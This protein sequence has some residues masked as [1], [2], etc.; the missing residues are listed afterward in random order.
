M[1]PSVPRLQMGVLYPTLMRD[2]NLALLERQLARKDLISLKKPASVPLLC[3]ANP[4]R[5]SLIFITLVRGE[6]LAGTVGVTGLS[7][8]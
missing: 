6:N 1:F 5:T 3:T 7:L 2:E 8:P 4:K